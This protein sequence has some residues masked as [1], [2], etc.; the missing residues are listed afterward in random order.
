MHS[1]SVYLAAALLSSTQIGGATVLGSFVWILITGLLVIFLLLPFGQQLLAK[2]VE[3]RRKRQKVL[4]GKATELPHNLS[5]QLN[6]LKKLLPLFNNQK[7]L[8]RTFQRVEELEKKLES[9][10]ALFLQV[11]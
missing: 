7:Q 11:S 8:D 1:R 10:R 3:Q 6:A 2:Q 9:L 4:L 5:A